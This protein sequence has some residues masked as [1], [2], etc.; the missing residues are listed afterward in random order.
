MHC[1]PR[2]PELRMKVRQSI[3]SESDS[4]DPSDPTTWV[5]LSSKRF[6][7][8]TSIARPKEYPNSAL[9]P[10]RMS[11]LDWTSAKS[12]IVWAH[13]WWVDGANVCSVSVIASGVS[14]DPADFVFAVR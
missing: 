2:P 7:A 11:Y 1:G 5:E 10:A 4:S 9:K 8:A 14:A 6:A 12:S 3:R 13:A